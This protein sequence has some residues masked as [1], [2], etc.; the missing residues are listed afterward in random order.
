MI[1][2]IS[3]EGINNTYK[4]PAGSNDRNVKWQELV[5][6][7]NQYLQRPYLH[8]SVQFKRI[9]SSSEHL[10]KS[11]LINFWVFVRSYFE[12]VIWRKW[13]GQ[14]LVCIT[15]GL[16]P[17]ME[18]EH[19]EVGFGKSITSDSPELFTFQKFNVFGQLKRKNYCIISTR[20]GCS[21]NA[22]VCLNG[23]HL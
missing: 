11:L 6:P 22:D 8:V 7:L 1:R 5:T 18:F 19:W 20:V 13:S 23:K 14:E 10:C 16:F 3:F 4:F 12:A 15:L 9:L 2:S 17:R 21:G